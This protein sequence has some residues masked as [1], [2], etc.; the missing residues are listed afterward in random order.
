MPTC[1]VCSTS[2]V[3]NARCENMLRSPQM[4]RCKRVYT[5][6]TVVLYVPS[7]SGSGYEQSG[8]ESQK[9]GTNPWHLCANSLFLDVEMKKNKNVCRHLFV[10]LAC[11][12][13][14]TKRLTH[15]ISHAGD[16]PVAG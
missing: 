6:S 14:H 16:E 4:E 9:C 15:V 7:M 10:V 1:R 2:V 5:C 13:E 8:F 3:I 12:L 11:A